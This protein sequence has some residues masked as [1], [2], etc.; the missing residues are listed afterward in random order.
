MSMGGTFRRL[1]RDQRER[2]GPDLQ[3]GTFGIDEAIQQKDA[4]AAMETGI[5]GQVLPSTG[6][7][8]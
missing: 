5:Y 6:G 3:N 4:T 2:L 1:R 7:S 8:H